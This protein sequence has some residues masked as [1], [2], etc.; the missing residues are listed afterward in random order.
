MK[1]RTRAA[2]NTENILDTF[3]VNGENIIMPFGI[4]FADSHSFFSLTGEGW[5]CEVEDVSS[6]RSSNSVSTICNIRL[7][8][9]YFRLEYTDSFDEKQNHIIRN[10]KLTAL[11]DSYLLDFVIRYRFVENAFDAAYID[12]HTVTHIH[13]NI[14]HQ[15]PTDTVLLGNQ[16]YRM[17]I[18][19]LSYQGTGFRPVSY[20]RDAK[21]GWIVHM[22][23]LPNVASKW[24]V[25][26]NARW[27]DRALPQLLSFPLRMPGIRERIAYWAERKPHQLR[28]RTISRY[29]SAYPLF[30]LKKGQQVSM[31]S[32]LSI[33]PVIDSE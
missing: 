1:I 15:Y 10:A 17:Q 13:K 4:E 29:I 24:I 22:R 28:R 27:Y 11:E 18:Q 14:Y 6:E 2:W 7:H 32:I 19:R 3:E 21:E 20:V 9:G 8:S 23:L 31:E 33:L 16:H 12:T 26:Y 5:G 25:K 30:H